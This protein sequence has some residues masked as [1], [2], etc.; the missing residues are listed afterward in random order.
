MSKSGTYN[1]DHTHIFVIVQN[2]ILTLIWQYTGQVWL[3]LGKRGYDSNHIEENRFLEYW[4]GLSFLAIFMLC[5]YMN[6]VSSLG[7][8]FQ[9]L[10]GKEEREMQGIC[11]AVKMLVTKNT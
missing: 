2:K 8:V 4:Q 1:N 6:S 7:F 9:N 3:F 10:G 5:W 11:N